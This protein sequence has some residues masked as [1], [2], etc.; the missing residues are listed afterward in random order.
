[1][2]SMHS[3]KTARYWD[4]DVVLFMDSS[5]FPSRLKAK[6]RGVVFNAGFRKCGFQAAPLRVAFDRTVHVQLIGSDPVN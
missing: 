4:R 1:M 2:N 5:G 3:V 6:L